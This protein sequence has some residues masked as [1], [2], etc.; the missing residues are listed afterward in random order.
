MAD[1]YDNCT[2]VT[3]TDNSIREAY[4]EGNGNGHALQLWS[5]SP[6]TV[7]IHDNTPT[8]NAGGIWIPTHNHRRRSGGRTDPSAG[9]RDPWRLAAG[10]P[11][12]RQYHV[13]G[14]CK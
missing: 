5:M 8:D 1:R 11:L 3:I 10:Q 12:L 9:V 6:W 4:S 13:R 2:A 14:G 7:D